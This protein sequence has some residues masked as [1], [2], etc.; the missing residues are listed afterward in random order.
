[1]HCMGRV[2]NWNGR[3]KSERKRN[4][5]NENNIQMDNKLLSRNWGFTR[6]YFSFRV[7]LHWGDRLPC[8][9]SIRNLLM[10]NFIDWNSWNCTKYNLFI[11]TCLR[12]MLHFSL[13]VLLIFSPK[14]KQQQHTHRTR[15]GEKPHKF[16]LFF[17][18]MASE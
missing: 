8:T 14:K 15:E 7:A 2:W 4:K 10:S 6:A 16:R 12:T 17:Q 5:Y 11:G 9:P 18:F 1:M 13:H 3:L